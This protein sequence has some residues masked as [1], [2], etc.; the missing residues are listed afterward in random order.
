MPQ[1]FPPHSEGQLHPVQEL[2]E[3]TTPPLPLHVEFR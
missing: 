1:V 2:P 3:V